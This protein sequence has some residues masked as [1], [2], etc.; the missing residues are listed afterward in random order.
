MKDTPPRAGDDCLPGQVSGA[1]ATDRAVC[2]ALPCTSSYAGY[3]V[4]CWLH[5]FLGFSNFDIAL[6]GMTV[7]GTVRTFGGR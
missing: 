4:G 7:G 1:A 5:F 2:F 6:S 3:C